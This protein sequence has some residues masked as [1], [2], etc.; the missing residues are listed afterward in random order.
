MAAHVERDVTGH[1]KAVVEE[2]KTSRGEFAKCKEELKECKAEFRE[3]REQRCWHEWKVYGMWDRIQQ[4]TEGE[5]RK[6]VLRSPPVQTE[7][8]YTVKLL[9][10]INDDEEANAG[11]LGLYVSFLPGPQDDFLRWPYEGKVT[12]GIVGV[13]DLTLDSDSAA[14]ADWPVDRLR[15]KP[16]AGGSNDAWGWT[17]FTP[18]AAVRGDCVTFRVKVEPKQQ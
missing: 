7:A 3:L 11:H 6:V 4:A 10:D 18:H 2:L 15:E 16:A 9:V 5:W 8:G 12:C 1:L 13:R 14:D 17:K